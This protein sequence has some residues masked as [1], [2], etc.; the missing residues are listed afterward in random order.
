MISAQTWD[1]A[2]CN[3]VQ[4]HRRAIK[5]G[6]RQ[7]RAMQSSPASGR[8]SAPIR[9]AVEQADRIINPGSMS[10][11]LSGRPVEGVEMGHKE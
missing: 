3:Q 7:L 4:L 2:L 10:G 9:L 8:V 1:L 5:E 6:R 11:T